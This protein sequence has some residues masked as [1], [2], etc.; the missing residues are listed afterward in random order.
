VE[1]HKRILS[2][3]GSEFQ[4]DSAAEKARQAMSVLVLGMDNR[5]MRAER[6]YLVAV[7]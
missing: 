6:R 1:V 2:L 3:S 4:T 7:D 5:G